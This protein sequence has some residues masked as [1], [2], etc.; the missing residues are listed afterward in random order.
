MPR[1]ICRIAVPWDMKVTGIE[2]TRLS[3]REVEGA[4]TMMPVQEPAPLDRTDIEWVEGSADVYSR[5]AYFPQEAAGDLHQGFMGD[6]RIAGFHVCPFRWNPV[7]R[8]LLFSEEIEVR[9]YLEKTSVIRP[10]RRKVAQRDPVVDMVERTVAN[11]RHVKSFMP[12]SGR[13]GLLGASQLQEDD[14]QYVIITR[15]LSLIHI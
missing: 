15:D 4:F 10:F 13:F 9:V 7:T 8:K 12:A 2:A 14:Y 11:P 5:D 6:S 1:K 3:E